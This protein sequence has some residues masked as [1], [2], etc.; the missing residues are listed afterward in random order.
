MLD[1]FIE[2]LYS[3]QRTVMYLPSYDFN[4]FEIAMTFSRPLALPTVD[5]FVMIFLFPLWSQ[6]KFN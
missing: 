2:I 1:V 5:V 3:S 4:K 6:R